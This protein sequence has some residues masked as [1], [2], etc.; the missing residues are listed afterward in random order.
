MPAR[1]DPRGEPRATPTA[2]GAAARIHVLLNPAARPAIR[3]VPTRDWLAERVPEATIAETDEP[4]RLR[5]LVEAA[6]READLLVLAGGDGLIHR[7]VNLLLPSLAAPVLGLVP[8]GTGNDLARSLGIPRDPAAAVR[9]LREGEDR[10]LDVGRARD[11]G[12]G[13]TIHFA[14]AALAGFGA[15][16]EPSPRA[17][18]RWGDRSYLLA[19]LRRLP[20]LS[21]RRVRLEHDGEERELDAYLI[22]VANGRFLGGGIPIAPGARPDDGRLDVVAV[23]RAPLP[24]LARAVVRLLRGAP[25]PAVLH[26]PARVVRLEVPEQWTLNLDGER[27]DFR[28]GRF[29]VVPGALRVRARRESGPPPSAPRAGRA[30]G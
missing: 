12:G 25:D 6:V 22:A 3:G 24:R 9:L 2:R 7:V 1:L 10:A 18:R 23:R 4:E 20:S 26:W 13:P 14:N 5:R 17:K 11:A 27:P 8:L 19:A 30:S 15:D 29:E 28:P 21:A 16:I